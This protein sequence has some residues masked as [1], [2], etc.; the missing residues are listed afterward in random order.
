MTSIFGVFPR[1][2]QPTALGPNAQTLGAVC[3][4]ADA[5]IDNREA[6]HR[7]L[8]LPPHTD[9]TTL[10]AQAYARWGTDCPR[11]LI[12]DYA[13]AIWDAAR[14]WL[15]CA[16]DHIGARPLYYYLTPQMAAIASDIPALIALDAVPAVIDEVEVA[17]YLVHH[18]NEYQP[19]ERTFFENVRRLRPGHTLTITPHGHRL[20]RYWDPQDYP[21]DR[22]LSLDDCVQRV[23][24]LTQQAVAYRVPMAGQVGF[25]LS[26]GIDSSSIAVLA[27]PYAT[28]RTHFY[29]WSR[30][31]DTDENEYGRIGA[32]TEMLGQTCQFIGYTQADHMTMLRIDPS[33]QPMDAIGRELPVL[34]QAAAD[35]VQ[36]I[37]SGWGGDETVSYNGR[38]VLAGMLRGGRWHDLPV[39]LGGLR[40]RTAAQLILLEGAYP[41][42]PNPL[43]RLVMHRAIRAR[44]DATF[45]SP[46]LAARTSG[47]TYRPAPL[48]RTVAGGPQS[49]ARLYFAEH[50]TRRIEAWATAARPHGIHYAYPLL[51]RPLMEF[52]Y[53]VPQAFH[54]FYGMRRFLYRKAMEPYLPFVW[55]PVK[56]ETP[57]TYR[58]HPTP[59]TTLLALTGDA[60]RHPWVDLPR[61]RATIRLRRREAYPGMLSALRVLQIV[62][63]P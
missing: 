55:E 49:Q 53:T 17:T 4:T 10:I 2:E 27:A 41:L 45:I 1:A 32:V 15:F 38:G 20:Q 48:T 52:V 62:R 28:N 43:L 60:A 36:T 16:R 63:T 18:F 57:H 8:Q 34:R 58:N 23:Q 21:E 42:L 50:L 3:I 39:A 9:D 59:P 29:S 30:P 13:F 33:V 31:V 26:G 12:G 22:S 46:E 25:H 19:G 56:S 40:K 5:R 35:G 11:H 37:L 51:D 24:E 47:R 14:G 7:R 61:L 44:P 54:L 6:L